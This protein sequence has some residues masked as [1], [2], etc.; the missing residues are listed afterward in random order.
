MI[1]STIETEALKD[2]KNA[3]LSPSGEVVIDADDFAP[4][5]AWHEELAQCIVRDLLHLETAR[6]TRDMVGPDKKHAYVF[7]WLEERGWIRYCGWAL[8]WV[9]S[10]RMRAAQ[11]RVIEQ[12]CEV[13]D[14]DWSK[15]VDVVFEP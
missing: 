11:R 2:L 10:T 13:N 8:K 4:M 7:E 5:G 12:W 6:E 14:Q 9:V 15:C 1:I 3:W